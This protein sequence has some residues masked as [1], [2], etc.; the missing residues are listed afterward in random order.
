MS[1]VH[2]GHPITTDAL[3]AMLELLRLEVPVK[4]AF[5]RSNEDGFG[6]EQL[7]VTGVSL[8]PAGFV[9][10]KVVHNDES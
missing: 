1:G 2:I 5:A 9:T 8:H 3:R 4:V 7:D 6:G 10:I